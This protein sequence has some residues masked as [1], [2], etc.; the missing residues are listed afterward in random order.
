MRARKYLKVT[1]LLI[2]KK[3]DVNTQAISS[4]DDNVAPID[5]APR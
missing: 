1:N 4:G 2:E 3:C 5:I